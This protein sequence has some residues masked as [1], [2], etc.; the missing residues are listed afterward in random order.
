MSQAL[1]LGQWGAT[2]SF[3]ASGV[4][5][6][7]R[8]TAADLVVQATG[9]I[10]LNVAGIAMASTETEVPVSLT[11]GTFGLLAVLA[12]LRAKANWHRIMREWVYA[13]PP[14]TVL[15]EAEWRYFERRGRSQT[16]GLSPV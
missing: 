9:P 11:T 12:Q 13:D 14:S 4:A 5:E 10:T 7:R 2:T 3:A 6:M 16:P 15:G 8:G 1:L